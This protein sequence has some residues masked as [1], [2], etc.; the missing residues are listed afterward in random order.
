MLIHTKHAVAMTA[1][2]VGEFRVVLDSAADQEFQSVGQGRIRVVEQPW[3][4][5]NL[6]DLLSRFLGCRV[7]AEHF[8]DVLE[9]GFVLERV[10][11]Y[12]VPHHGPEVRRWQER[13]Y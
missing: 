11:V 9:M 8:V 2:I 1:I 5:C 3:Y 6:S 13:E 12:G 7:D 10:L 4:M